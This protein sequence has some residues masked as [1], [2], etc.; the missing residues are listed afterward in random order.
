MSLYQKQNLTV[1]FLQF[2]V[3]TNGIIVPI[4]R[5]GKDNLTKQVSS[6]SKAA[7]TQIRISARRGKVSL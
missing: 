2:G 4:H 3:D 1:Q 7:G 5:R 6:A